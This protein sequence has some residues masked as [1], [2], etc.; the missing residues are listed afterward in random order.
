VQL[1]RHPS[2][3]HPPVAFGQ[4]GASAHAP[5]DT[6]EAF[7][8]AL[9]LGARGISARARLSADGAVLLSHAAALGRWPRR[10]RVGQ[11]NRADVP[12]LVTLDELLDVT[13]DDTIVSLTVGNDD[14]AVGAVDVMSA[15][16]P[17]TR[18]WLVHDDHGAL[19][20]WRERWPEPMLVHHGRIESLD[21]GPERHA[22]RLAERGMSGLSMPAADWTGGL[23]TLI[24]RF[25]LDAIATD[26]RVERVFVGLVRMGIDAV[27]TGNVELLVDVVGREAGS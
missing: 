3:R 25:E 9:V 6:V 7:E 17:L 2:R 23:T 11:V 14:E 12:E 18:L 24:H 8:L 21:G 4:G 20:A 1:V 13:G 15:R 19:G 27:H 16:A 22:A 26:A 10:R 5:A